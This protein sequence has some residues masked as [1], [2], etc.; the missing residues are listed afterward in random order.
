MHSAEVNQRIG[1]GCWVYRV[2]LR[3]EGLRFDPKMS[4]C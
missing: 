2:G 3:G 1:T 4:C